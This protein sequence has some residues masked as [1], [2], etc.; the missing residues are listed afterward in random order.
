MERIPKLE[1]RGLNRTHDKKL[2]IIFCNISTAPVIHQDKSKNM[3]VHIRN[4]DTITQFVPFTNN[5][6]LT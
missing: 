6:S 5:K 3:I 1:Y 2:Q 4:V